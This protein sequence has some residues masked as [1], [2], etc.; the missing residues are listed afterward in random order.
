MFVDEGEYSEEEENEEEDD[1]DSDFLSDGRMK[2]HFYM[3]IKGKLTDE[4]KHLMFGDAIIYIENISCVK[5]NNIMSTVFY[6]KYTDN[7]YQY[8]FLEYD[9]TKKDIVCYYEINHGLNELNERPIF[10]FCGKRMH[11]SCYNVREMDNH[12]IIRRYQHSVY[13]RCVV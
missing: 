8:Y 9:L 1:N 6:F 7:I 13:A 3:E 4:M 2:H 10:R 5:E 11:I 12:Y